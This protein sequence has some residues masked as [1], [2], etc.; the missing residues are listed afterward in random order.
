MNEFARIA[1][2][3]IWPGAHLRPVG[4][5]GV[6]RSARR[7]GNAFDDL[8]ELLH[9]VAMTAGKLDEL[10]GANGDLTSRRGAGDRDAAAALKL[11]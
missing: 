4:L 9:A 3:P 10:A 11:E 8:H 2:E 7:L 1:F 5:F 6:C